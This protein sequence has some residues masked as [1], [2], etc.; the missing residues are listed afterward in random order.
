MRHDRFGGEESSACEPTKYLDVQRG[1]SD[2]VEIR[3]KKSL[4]SS[5]TRFEICDWA[6][7]V[8]VVV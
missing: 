4:T 1:C 8:E 7:I 6:S 2:V 3:L 5:M